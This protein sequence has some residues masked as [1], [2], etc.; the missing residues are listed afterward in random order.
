MFRGSGPSS[1]L[2]GAELED[3]GINGCG[4]FFSGGVVPGSDGERA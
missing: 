2:E 3:A 1:Y 4:R